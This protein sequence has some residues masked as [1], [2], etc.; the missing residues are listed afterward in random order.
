MI[1][2]IV[3][4]D[5]HACVL[6]KQ[7]KTETQGDNSTDHINNALECRED[8]SFKKLSGK[9]LRRKKTKTK[10]RDKESENQTTNLI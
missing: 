8:P 4:K 9:K 6:I 1:H 7:R 3:G 2:A 5:E 10:T